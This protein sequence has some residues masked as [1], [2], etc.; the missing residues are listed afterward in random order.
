MASG[1]SSAPSFLQARPELQFVDLLIPDM[2][3][4][5][6]GK[7]V[8]PSALA[9][10]FERGVAMPASIFALNIQGTTVEETGLG[11]DIGEADRVC[12]PIE[13]TLTM[14]PWQKRPTA[15]L[16][17][18]MYELDRET[19]FFADPRVVLQN[20]MKRFEEL[21]LLHRQG[22]QVILHP[23]ALPYARAIASTF[24]AYLEPREQRFSHAV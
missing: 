18:T 1:S 11:L 4:I 10:V 3:G 23:T 7:R 16:L 20:I 14:E 21:G 9:K 8:D 22:S 15:Q 12:L 2:N 5:V 6:R 19:P 13:N 17:L 24:D